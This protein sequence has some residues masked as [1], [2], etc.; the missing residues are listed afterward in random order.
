MNCATRKL[1]SHQ[2]T[3]LIFFPFGV[4]CDLQH[5]QKTT[6]SYYKEHLLVRRLSFGFD[7]EYTQSHNTPSSG[8]KKRFREAEYSF[9][10]LLKWFPHLCWPKVREYKH[11]KLSCQSCSGGRGMAI[12]MVMLALWGNPIKQF[13]GTVSKKS[14][15]R[16]LILGVRHHYWLNFKQFNLAVFTLRCRKVFFVYLSVAKLYC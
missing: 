4:Q 12:V 9:S 3:L 6:F 16:I 2:F 11:F 7:T 10:F 13:L 5:V 15:N 14:S 1:P 8:K